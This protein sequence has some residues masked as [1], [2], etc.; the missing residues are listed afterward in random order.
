MVL[1]VKQENPE[2]TV[3]MVG[4]ENQVYKV[5]RVFKECPA[6]ME[7]LDVLV[8]LV[9]KDYLAQEDQEELPVRVVLL[10]L[11]D[12]KVSEDIKVI[13]VMLV[14]TAKEELPV[15]RANKVRWV[16]LASLV[17]VAFLVS[18]DQPE[19]LVKLVGVGLVVRLVLWV[20]LV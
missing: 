17:N 14:S 12:Q 11:Q 2:K 10:D 13:K 8:N 7:K 9:L 1:L 16:I 3:G 20:R 15:R 18:V 19:A 4:L 6:K 5:L